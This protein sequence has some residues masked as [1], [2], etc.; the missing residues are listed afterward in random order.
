MAEDTKKP[1]G[2]RKPLPRGGGD[3]TASQVFGIIGKQ[4]QTFNSLQ[5]AIIE[6]NNDLATAL[7]EEMSGLSVTF[8]DANDKLDIQIGQFTKLISLFEPVSSYFTELKEDSGAKSVQPKGGKAKDG[9]VVVSPDTKGLKTY[10]DETEKAEK[11]TGGFM[12]KLTG[13]VGGRAGAAAGGAAGGSVAGVLGGVGLGLGAVGLGLATITGALYIGAKAVEVFGEG[14]QEVSQGMDEL[15]NLDISTQKF[16]ELGYALGQLTGSTTFGGTVNLLLLAKT[17]F[18]DLAA[19]MKALNDTQFDEENLS[20]A[21]DGINAFLNNVDTNILAGITVKLVDDSLIPLARG[22][23]AFNT[24]KLDSNFEDDMAAAGKGLSAFMSEQAGFKNLFGSFTLKFIDENLS[25]L[26]TGITALNNAE[27]DSNFVDDMTNAGIGINKLLTGMGSIFDTF[28]AKLIDDNLGVLAE[29]I[30]SL[31]KVDA[32]AFVTTGEQLGTGFKSLLSGFSMWKGLS[33]EISEDDLGGL[34][35]TIN[36]LNETDGVKFQK[37]GELIGSGFGSILGGF[38]SFLASFQL[39]MI[40]DDLVEFA[41]GLEAISKVDFDEN[42]VKSMGYMG[43]GI[44]E[45]IDNLT[46]MDRI[47]ENDTFLEG[48]FKGLKNIWGQ[49]TGWITT[50]DFE[51]AIK[52]LSELG[53][54]M[55]DL[56]KFGGPELIV[57]K[58]FIGSTEDLLGNLEGKDFKDENLQ[59]L[60]D[61]LKQ[62]Q[63]LDHKKLTDISKAVN[64]FQGG[65]SGQVLDEQALSESVASAINQSINNVVNAGGNTTALSNNIETKQYRVSRGTTPTVIRFSK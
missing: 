27:I 4:V 59:K 25:V 44:R 30:D 46:G 28:T 24:V 57:F 51:S 40:S 54:A 31:N 33:L 15:N 55:T 22:I 29:G 39:S 26:A 45:L 11:A 16:E 20:R 61:K 19:G 21:A 36:N 41:D 42:T 62:I 35:T 34:H 13:L 23:E 6:G 53:T 2:P 3:K 65:S 32:V 43:D 38:S 18:S 58:D 50:S 7:R 60:I 12:S 9:D 8:N 63:N 48:A 47:D 64:I 49:L 17:Q 14:L 10:T 5:K 56:S 52:P 37:Q 1:N